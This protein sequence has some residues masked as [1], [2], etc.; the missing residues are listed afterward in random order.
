MV[1][2]S[3]GCGEVRLRRWVWGGGCGEVGVGLN[4]TDPNEPMNE[5]IYSSHGRTTKLMGGV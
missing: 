4:D 1:V 2:R 3:C 5:A